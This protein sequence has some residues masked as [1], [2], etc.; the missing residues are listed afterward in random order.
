MSSKDKKR[1]REYKIELPRIDPVELLVSEATQLY[2]QLNLVD[3]HDLDPNCNGILPSFDEDPDCNYQVHSRPP[4][5]GSL[6]PTVLFSDDPDLNDVI[7]KYDFE[8]G[9]IFFFLLL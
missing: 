7:E 2:N 6:E 5:P 4:S 1:S 3:H 9:M 8:S